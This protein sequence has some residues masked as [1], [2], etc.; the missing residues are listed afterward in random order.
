ML[1]VSFWLFSTGHFLQ[2]TLS[3]VSEIFDKQIFWP[4][5]EE[6]RVAKTASLFAARAGVCQFYKCPE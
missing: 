1:R 6:L 4:D 3:V 5:R 2:N